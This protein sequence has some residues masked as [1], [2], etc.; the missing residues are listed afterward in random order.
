MKREVIGFAAATKMMLNHFLKSVCLTLCIGAS[1]F[2]LKAQ[3]YGG[4]TGIFTDYGGFWASEA[5]NHNPILP[6]N[7]HHL[8]GFRWNGINYSTGVNDD[9]LALEGVSFSPQVYQAF[10]VRNIQAKPSGTY[11]GLG[12]M[13]D[14]VDNGISVPPPFNVPPNLASFLT[15][16]I[17]GL[18]FGT[19]VANIA[20]GNLIFDFSGI[21]DPDQ[22]G[23][24]I[25]DILVSQFADPSSVLDEIYMADDV[26]NLIG[27]SLAIDHTQVVRVGS[28]SADFYELNGNSA[29]FI[30]G[31]RDLRLWV[32][33]L[34]A[35]GIDQNNYD[36]VRSM[37]YRLNGT[38]DPA[39]AAYKV[40]VFDILA[41]N[42]DHGTTNQGEPVV[43]TVLS[44]D[45]P[46][47]IL[48]SNTVKILTGPSNGTVVI[49]QATGEIQYIPNEEFYGSDEFTYEVCDSSELQCD[50]AV[51]YIDVIQVPLPVSWLS[52]GGYYEKDKGVVLEWETAQEKDCDHFNILTSANGKEWKSLGIVSAGGDSNEI[53]KYAFIDE[54]PQKGRVYY[55]IKQSDH[56]GSYEYSDVISIVTE[57]YRN[58]NISFKP[59]PVGDKLILE[60]TSHELSEIGIY[61]ISGQDVSGETSIFLIA[62]DNREIEVKK[63]PKGKYVLKTKSQRLVFLKE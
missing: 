46:I 7:T 56:D 45:L 29:A 27:N 14:G 15:S 52:F 61:S 3:D 34:S 47:E 62:D 4:S 57:K 44:N 30:K 24:G 53:Q 54:Y 18:N 31:S 33:D 20:A 59:N 21:I 40:G 8:L 42:N 12:Q 38:S 13:Y 51:V 22:I 43:I 49:D 9:R 36:Q 39:F 25:P 60:G 28:W 2:S 26:G 23:D 16:G 37:R 63:L 50:E 5:G 10:P 17:Q 55:R 58:T 32:A 48:D 6:D 11:I 35:F 1:F 19:G 41:A